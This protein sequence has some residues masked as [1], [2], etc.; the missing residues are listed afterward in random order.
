MNKIID[1]KKLFQERKFKEII[2]NIENRVPE[3]EKT[4]GILN[5]LGACRLLKGKANKKDLFQAL[6]DF[7]AAYLKE[8]KTNHS[9][10]AFINFANVSIDLFEYENTAENH[11]MSLKN[12]KDAK[13]FFEKE[14][15][16]KNDAKA[17]LAII[18][19]YKRL[20][21]LKKVNKCLE[22]LIKNKNLNPFVLNNYIYHNSFFTDWTQKDY[23]KYAKKLDQIL[24]LYPDNKLV[25]L[26]YRR[27]KKIK[28]GFLSSDLFG[29]HP[30]TNFLK[31]ILLNYNSK[32]FEIIL[33]LNS[34]PKKED[35]TTKNLKK[36]SL[37]SQII[38]DLNDIDA[39]N[40]IRSDK[41][42]IL[43][44]LM[45]IT[46]KSRLT[47]IK[48]RVAPVQVSWCGYCNTTGVKEMDYI[49]TDPNLIF[50]Q[51]KK[52]Y[53]ES[54]IYLP[55]IWNA[56]AGIDLERIYIDPPFVKN[57][58]ITFGSFNNF[59]KINDDVIYVWSEILKNTPNSKLIL[60][61]SSVLSNEVI[62]EKFKNNN[63]LDSVYFYPYSSD[64]K[65][66]M[67]DY[68]KIDIALDTFPYPGVT[69]SF[70]AIWMGVPVVTK[71][72]FNFISRCGE[73]IS[74][75]LNMENLISHND[76]DYIRLACEIATN[77][78]KLIKIRQEIFNT[79][80]FTPLFDGKNFSKEFFNSLKKTLK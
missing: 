40:L 34:Q 42:D 28:V 79:A 47:L 6:N 78:Q 69:T 46:S 66:H 76:Q 31:T 20:V 18:R 21:D 12:F 22:H 51:E 77:K 7:R 32:E 64:F 63:V 75:N 29:L 16:L 3:N 2:F 54:V 65:K 67:Y 23:L 62:S 71:R 53:T 58:F 26:N 9:K 25:S 43:V 14:D 48:N 10:E 27:D 35:E 52:D 59:R 44:D 55:K 73:S 4:S 72:G 5:V 30:V 15:H 41:I 37:K 70:E 11:A 39:I 80:L 36:L 13:F 49:I 17:V 60:K 57:K 56:H 68:K 24:P 38:F 45:G 33:Y 74:K 50:K 1:L 8:K 61:S 19:I